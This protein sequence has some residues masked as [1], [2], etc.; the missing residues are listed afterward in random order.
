[1]HHWYIQHY[2]FVFDLKLMLL[3][4]VVG[5]LMRKF[6]YEGAPLIL[7]Y[8]LGPLMEQALRQSLLISDGSFM[9]L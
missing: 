4:G 9:N 1:M 6:R 2:R 7:A 5:Y 8:V 3:F